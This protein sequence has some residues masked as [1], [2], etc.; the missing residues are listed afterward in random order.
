[1]DS[2]KDATLLDR[3]ANWLG[4]EKK[5]LNVD[6]MPE[7]LRPKAQQVK[8]S[9]GGGSYQS[10]IKPVDSLNSSVSVESKVKSKSQAPAIPAATFPKKSEVTVQD[11]RG[12]KFINPFKGTPEQGVSDFAQSATPIIDG[13]LK[14]GQNK[15]P[16]TFANIS[17][18]K[19]ERENISIANQF[20]EKYRDNVMNMDRTNL[21]PLMALADKWMGGNTKLVE[22]YKSPDSIDEVYK[23]LMQLNQAGIK[24]RDDAELKNKQIQLDAFNDIV[25]KPRNEFMKTFG[26]V[27]Q[28]RGRDI[29]G[30]SRVINSEMQSAENSYAN[31]YTRAQSDLL[32][33]RTSKDI[34]AAKLKQRAEEVDRKINAHFGRT[35]RESKQQYWDDI[36]RTLA[37]FVAPKFTSK[38]RAL[39]VDRKLWGAKN[40]AEMGAVLKFADYIAA[41]RG[42]DTGDIEAVKRERL[43]ALN[44]I[45]LGYN[46]DSWTDPELKMLHEDYTKGSN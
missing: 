6:L 1:M 28:G 27:N 35:G 44:D 25:L 10:R 2:N 22:S 14:A 5:G 16:T 23:T 34:E 29:S 36:D 8:P 43:R 21:G 33:S 31:N 39:P 11:P 9:D 3:L 19:P 13:L 46:N 12:T 20:L 42:V 7:E 45:A 30:L 24:Q 32:Q 38:G 17:D 40:E 41:S 26:Q 18:N 4:Y 15:S 37:T